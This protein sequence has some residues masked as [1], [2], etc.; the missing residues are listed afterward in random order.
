MKQRGMIRSLFLGTILLT[1]LAVAAC[2]A[3]PETVRE[4]TA[5][6]EAEVLTIVDEEG[7]TDIDI[8]HLNTAIEVPV[9]SELSATDIE[10]L[11]FM[12]EEEKLARDVYLA[13]YDMWGVNIFRNIASSEESHTEAVRVL[14]ERYSLEDPMDV[15]EPG[16][17]VNADLQA[18]YDDLTALGS[19]SLVDALLVGAAIEE[20]DI[21]D[22]EEY[23]ART[24]NAEI[25]LVYENLLRG[26]RNHL[27]SF[28]RQIESRSGPYQP[29][30][31]T[32][33]AYDAILGSGIEVG[34]NR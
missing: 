1:T 26:S 18:L 20:I 19:Q 11:L 3:A 31:L 21:L 29:Q 32:R 15:D 14:I 27:R 24:D 23:V 7:N 12:R 25:K 30:Y 22:L 28:V 4:D 13:L 9:D 34:G 6:P 17:F 33:D 2:G 8:Q 16:V 10:G 5:T